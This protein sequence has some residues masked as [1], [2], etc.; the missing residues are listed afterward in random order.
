MSFGQQT[1]MADKGAGVMQVKD[2]LQWGAD[3]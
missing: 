1:A 2:R 3:V